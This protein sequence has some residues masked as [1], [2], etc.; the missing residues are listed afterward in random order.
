MLTFRT[1]IFILNKNFALSNIFKNTNLLDKNLQIIIQKLQTKFLS[2]ILLKMIISFS[3]LITQIFL[4]RL[5]DFALNRRFK[6]CPLFLMMETIE[7][8]WKNY[9]FNIE[10]HF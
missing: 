2:L 3:Y 1:F 4:A 10:S 8:Y 5:R 9:C 6:D 7:T